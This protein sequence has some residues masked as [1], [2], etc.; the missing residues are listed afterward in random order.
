MNDFAKV[1]DIYRQYFSENYPARAAYQVAALP[2]GGRVEI[3]AIA[4]VGTFEDSK[5]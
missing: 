1:N 4:V 2:K 3:E 5:L